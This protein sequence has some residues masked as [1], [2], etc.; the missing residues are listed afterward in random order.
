MNRVAVGLSIGS[1]VVAIAAIFFAI[2][3]TSVSRDSEWLQ[4]EMAGLR[5]DLTSFQSSVAAELDKLHAEQ[6]GLVAKTDM[7]QGI[8]RVALTEGSRSGDE[9]PLSAEPAL[10]MDPR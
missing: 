3:A 10:L 7:L 5:S 6:R 1:T 8:G 9:E 2:S 4:M